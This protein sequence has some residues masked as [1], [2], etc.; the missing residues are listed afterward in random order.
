MVKKIDGFRTK[1]NPLS[2]AIGLIKSLRNLT[3]RN[4]ITGVKPI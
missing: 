1:E 4:E 2:W 3:D